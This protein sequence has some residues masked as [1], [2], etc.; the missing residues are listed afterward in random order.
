[1]VEVGLY[2]F[3]SNPAHS[4]LAALLHET[5]APRSRLAAR[6]HETDAPRSRRSVLRHEDRGPGGAVGAPQGANG[7]LEPRRPPG[8][9]QGRRFEVK[10]DAHSG[11]ILE[12]E[13][14]RDKR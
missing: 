8:A 2:P 13:V 14:K 1:V 7:A 3:C 4:R 10:V 11:E 9:G 6:L 5:D 12:V